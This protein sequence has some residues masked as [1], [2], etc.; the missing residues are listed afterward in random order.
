MK[1]IVLVIC[2]W[3]FLYEAA[4]AH[5]DPL[6]DVHPVVLIES[7][8]FAIYFSTNA[9]GYNYLE[10]DQ[11]VFRMLY[12]AKGRLLAP[13]H[14][15]KNKPVQESAINIDRFN[16]PRPNAEISLP[17]GKKQIFALA[18]PKD[19]EIIMVESSTINS[20]HIVIALKGAS[21]EVDERDETYK[22]F[23]LYLFPREGFAKPERFLIGQPA[24]IYDFPTASNVVYANGKFWIAWVRERKKEKIEYEMV[25][26]CVVPGS[27]EITERI[28][29]TP[30]DWN[31]HLSMAVIGDRLCLAYH[32]SVSHEYP[33]TSEIITV[34]VKAE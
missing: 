33:G 32:C 3:V 15:V 19:F 14:V 23:F 34:F 17:G 8:N 10:G 31:S 7:G 28:L 16:N 5:S 29:D 20:D 27:G 11:P 13:R 9:V 24:T 12:T 4:L 26:S 6:G 25:L 18:W 30:A 22:D 21:A 1:K 2:C